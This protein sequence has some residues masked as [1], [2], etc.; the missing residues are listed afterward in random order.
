MSKQCLFLYNVG[1]LGN[2]I[3]TC[4]KMKTK[5]HNTGF[6]L[7]V[8][9]MEIKAFVL[10]LLASSAFAAS[11]GMLVKNGDRI[12]FMGDSITHYGVERSHGYVRLTVQGLAANGIEVD[13][14][15]RGVPGEKASQMRARFQH[16]VVDSHPAIVTISAGVNDVALSDQTPASGPEDVEAMVQMAKAAGITPVVMTPTF[17]EF[18]TENGEVTRAYAETVRGYASTYDVPLCDTWQAIMD[19]KNSSATP[20]LEY[21]LHYKA[22][23]DGVHMAPAGDRVMARTLLRALGLDDGQMANAEA[24]WN[25]NEKV[26]SIHPAV[27]ITS[28]QLATFKQAAANAGMGGGEFSK[29]VFKRGLASLA[30]NPSVEQDSAGS[31][32]ET[33]SAGFSINMADYDTL[34]GTSLAAAYH[35]A[36]SKQ[37]HLDATIGMAMLRGIRECEAGEPVVVVPQDVQT[38]LFSRCITFTASG[39]AGESALADFPVAV[40]L[41]ANMPAGFSYA[42]MSDPSSGSELRFA[43]SDGKSLDYDVEEWNADGASLVWVKVPSLTKTTTFTMYYGGTPTDEVKSIRAWSADYVGVWHMSEADGN[44]SDSAGNGLTASPNGSGASYSVAG[45]GVFGKARVNTSVRNKGTG[46]S[47]LVVSDSYLLDL[48]SDFTMSGWVK[49]TDTIDGGGLAR[50]AVRSADGATPEWEVALADATTLQASGNGGET[51]SGQIPSAMNSWRHVAAVYDGA[52]LKVYVDGTVVLDGAITAAKDSNNKLCFGTKGGLYNGHF[53]GLFDEFRLRDAACSADWVKA[54]FDQSAASFLSAGAVSVLVPGE[55]QGEGGGQS[56]GGGSEEGGSGGDAPPDDTSGD[57]TKYITFTTSGYQGSAALADFPVLVRL[58]TAISG[59]SYADFG[60]ATNFVF[61][62]SEGGVLPCEIESWNPGGVSLVWVKVPSVTNTSRFTMHYGG[63][64]SADGDSASTWTAS[65]Y[66]GVWHMAESEGDVADATGHGL[67]A[68]QMG[69]DTTAQVATD[70]A[71]GGAR[72]NSTSSS[73]SYFEVADAAQL[74][75]GGTFTVSGWYRLSAQNGSE[76]GV[77]GRQW[78]WFSTD[79]WMFELAKGSATGFYARGASNGSNSMNASGEMPSALNAWVHFALV[80][81]GAGVTV[82]ANGA[83]V[84]TSGAINAAKDNNMPLTLGYGNT[85]SYL[86][87]ALDEFRLK[88]GA[89]SADWVKAEY[90]QAGGMFLANGGV[91]SAE[92]VPAQTQGVGFFVD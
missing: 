26:Y 80:Y 48:G 10:A 5:I 30:A 89:A 73:K 65:G 27:K 38:N 18:N 85:R 91:Q 70:G 74:D 57:F 54:E 24:A 86:Y 7:L 22:T 46:R 25:A 37:G 59:F 35:P 92:V 69:T 16:D 40:R 34:L 28:A 3:K 39:Y 82:Y 9:A 17:A 11:G 78:G 87:G 6:G 49:M 64:T 61:K 72:V 67:T 53:T 83:P 51:L 19:W 55:G 88:S 21:Q 2:K 23:I 8:S 84:A 12:V 75:V 68:R 66:V 60:S 43:D 71:I 1:V 36:T 63:S 76:A 79:G 13:W 81:E 50:I 4:K 77:V 41:A 29:V 56:G 58:S 47:M 31:G 62:D 52:A 90:D 32:V 44:V 42:D 14:I 33:F 15:G 20:Y 45:Q